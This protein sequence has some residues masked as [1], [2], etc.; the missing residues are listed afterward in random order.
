MTNRPRPT[1][2]EW[3]VM[4]VCWSAGP[5]SARALHKA[6]LAE[7]S[8]LL[9]LFKSLQFQSFRTLLL[10]LVKKGYLRTEVSTK[11][12]ITSGG[13]DKWGVVD[14]VQRYSPDR[15]RAVAAVHSCRSDQPV[16]VFSALDP[17]QAKKVQKELESAG[18]TANTDD[19]LTFYIPAVSKKEAVADRS[20]AFVLETTGG[21]EEA[22][23]YLR[24][25][26]DKALK[27]TSADKA[28]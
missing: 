20:T 18:A 3:Q 6:S 27:E 4:L 26:I 10:R 19:G 11:V 5:A 17:K 9:R 23:R 16:P 2:A 1:P 14:I 13:K 7:N 21:D 22:K 8:P 25:S 12:V 28:S 15:D 24:E